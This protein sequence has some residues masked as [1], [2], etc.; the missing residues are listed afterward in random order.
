MKKSS[1][2]THDNYAYL[3]KLDAQGWAWEF[4]RRG[5]PYQDA[6]KQYEKLQ[7]QYGEGWQKKQD[8]VHVPKKLSGESHNAWLVRLADKGL[9]GKMLTPSQKC[10]QAVWHLHDMYNPNT[11]YDKNI[12]QF[13]PPAAHPLVYGNPPENRSKVSLHGLR[14]TADIEEDIAE[15]LNENALIV[16]FHPQQ[17]AAAQ[18]EKARKMLAAYVRLFPQPETSRD[19]ENLWPLYIKFLDMLASTKPIS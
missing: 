18:I 7:Q 10:A 2:A 1:D 12:V 3:D 15:F 4:M 11:Q 14:H 6:Y 17:N 9:V 13:M 16:C 19:R 5:K 8:T